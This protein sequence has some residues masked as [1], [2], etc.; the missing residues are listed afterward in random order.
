MEQAPITPAQRTKL[1]ENIRGLVAA[2]VKYLPQPGNLTVVNT[3]TPRGYQMFRY[4]EG[5][6][7]SVDASQPLA[8][9]NHL[10]GN[11]MFFLATHA[12][13]SIDDYNL[14]IDWIKRFAVDLERARPAV[15]PRP[16]IGLI[17]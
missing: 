11:P 9:L 12:R 6:L 8:V 2:I 13:D 10:G 4:N 14:G 16:R 17:I 3:L 15:C 5:T 1:S 7:P